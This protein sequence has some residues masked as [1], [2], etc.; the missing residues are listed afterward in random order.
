MNKMNILKRI[1]GI[2]VAI[3]MTMGMDFSYADSTGNIDNKVYQG[4]NTVL[5]GKIHEP[6]S[7]VVQKSDFKSNIKYTKDRKRATILIKLPSL[8][9]V[10]LDIR[11][12][13]I[14]I[15]IPKKIA[16]YE[17][18]TQ[19]ISDRLISNYEFVDQGET[20]KFDIN[21]KTNVKAEYTMNEA[22]GEISINLDKLAYDMPKIVIDAGHGGNDP[23]AISKAV[24]VNEKTLNLQVANIL[25]DK[26]VASG[27][28][29]VMNR[30]S[31]YF[32]PLKDRYNNANDFD[33]DLF[34][35][36]HHNSTT[37]AATS[38]IET[39]HHTSRDNKEIAVY[40]QDELIKNTGAVNRGTKVRTDLAVLNGT[41]MPAVLVELGFM[42]NSNELSKL[43]DSIYQNT[44]ADA[45]LV[46]IN[47]YF[48][49]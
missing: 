7:E 38:G 36:I 11:D 2:T 20:Y 25:R 35:S 23:G 29:V 32:V 17:S 27:Y 18:F 10:K 12:S 34:V 48:G 43:R 33:A 21:L 4:L 3:T 44:L 13:K 26:L 45:M 46:G 24:G 8:E 22:L 14:S 9:N 1:M 40:I 49:R 19:E 16:S 31:D 37:N 41:K 47:K 39:L 30:D 42:T 28:E 5:E 6:P 15:D